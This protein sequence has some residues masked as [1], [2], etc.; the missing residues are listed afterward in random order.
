MQDRLEEQQREYDELLVQHEEV[1]A[2]NHKLHQLHERPK[3][4]TS[5]QVIAHPQS[6]ATGDIC[7]S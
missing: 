5:I 3:S 6:F 2:I 4:D 7:L 1:C